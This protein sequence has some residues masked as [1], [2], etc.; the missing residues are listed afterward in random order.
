MKM[1]GYSTLFIY[2]LYV[3]VGVFYYVSTLG[4]LSGFSD[5][6][7]YYRKQ[8]YV[9]PFLPFFNLFVFFIR[10][11]GVI[12]SINTNSAWKTKNFT[13]ERK[14]AAQVM[15]GDFGM[16]CQVFRRLRCYVNGEKN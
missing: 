13:Q 8:W 16:V 2:F 9:I 14:S 3:C 10:F 6:R 1:V 7:K 11:A 15:L 12:N 5:L 4:F